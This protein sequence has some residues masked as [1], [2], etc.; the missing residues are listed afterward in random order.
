MQKLTKII[1]ILSLIS[2]SLFRA[3]AQNQLD[4]ERS[5]LMP[6]EEFLPADLAHQPL[7]V[8]DSIFVNLITNGGK[9]T[10]PSELRHRSDRR[11]DKH[12]KVGYYRILNRF[13]STGRLLVKKYTKPWYI[14]KNTGRLFPFQMF[15]IN[16]TF[17]FLDEWEEDKPMKSKM[18]GGI[19]APPV[20]QYTFFSKN[21]LLIQDSASQYYFLLTDYT[22]MNPCRNTNTMSCYWLNCYSSILVLDKRMN[23]IVYITQSINCNDAHLVTIQKGGF[24]DA[25]LGLTWKGLKEHTLNDLAVLIK[26]IPKPTPDLKV[27]EKDLFKMEF[28]NWGQ[29]I[30]N[31][32]DW[33]NR[34]MKKLNIKE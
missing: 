31:D 30:R 33:E 28:H 26:K 15:S 5:W 24:Y 32:Y 12:E 2:L 19:L 34:K 13:D 17:W 25:R 6:Y 21:C 20:E 10:R 27:H 22:N 18:I 9:N 3:D 29:R 7:R 11:L 14:S 1:L 23:P 4:F 16:Q 8:M